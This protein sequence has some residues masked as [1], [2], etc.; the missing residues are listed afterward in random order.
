MKR[1]LLAG[2]LS[3]SLCTGTVGAALPMEADAAQGTPQKAEV[4]VSGSGITVGNG[5]I[6]RQ[7]EISGGKIKTS[8][9]QN[10]RI[11]KLLIPQDG[12]QDFVIHT[13]KPE[14][15]DG[16]DI[17]VTEVFPQ[18]ALD[19][20]GWSVSI[21]NAAGTA[22]SEEGSKKLIDGDIS[23]YP[24][25]YR[26]SGNPFTVDIDFG[27]K[28]EI[29]SMS[30]DK[31]PGF[32][33]SQYG[34]N[35]T[36]GKFELYTSED[37]EAYHLAYTGDFKEE[38]YQ[39]HEEGG[40]YNVGKTVYADFGGTVTARFVRLV[41]KTCSL[42]T[43]QEFSSAELTIYEDAYSGYDWADGG[44]AGSSPDAI[45]SG[46][47]VYEGSGQADIEGGKKLSIHY[48][49]YEKNGV[50]WDIDQ[51]V[52]IKDDEHYMRSF[53]EI[54]V[55]DPERAAI[56][57]IDTDRFVLS[58]GEE[59]L[60][61]HPKDAQIDSYWMNAHEQM[62]GQPIYAQGMFF[63]CE[64]P[65]NDNIIEDNQI[66]IR[67]YSGKNFTK[68][69]EDGQL[70]VDGKFVSWQNVIGAAEGTDTSVVQTA[71]FDYIEDIATPTQFRKQYNSWYDNMMSITDE[72][73]AASFYGVEDGLSSNGVEPLDCYVV[74]DGWNNYYYDEPD[75]GLPEVS[76]GSTQGTTPNKTG[77]WEFN[78]KFPNEL[79]TSASLSDKLK[80][81]FGMW[82]GPQGGYNYYTSFAKFLEYKGTGEVQPNSSL[83]QVI[84]TGSRTYL[85]NF[86]KMALDYQERFDIDYWKWDGF[87]SRPCSS[88]S[89]NHMAGG[90]DNMYFTSDMWEAWTD[91]FEHVRAQRQG[92][93]KGLFI[94][95]TCY[96]NL[97]PW[98]L[99]WV[100]TVWLQE[101]GDTGHLG[102]GER[103]QQKIYYRDQVYYK[104]CKK[105]EAQF[106]LKNI[107]NHDPI[108]G[109]SDNS[110]AGTDVFREFLFANAVRGTAFWELYFSPSIMDGDKWKV[111][112]DALFWAQ[113][114]HEILKNA[115]LFGNEP[116]KGVYGYSCWKGDQGIVSFTNP[117]DSEQTYELLV[118]D[119]VGAGKSLQNATGI[120]VYPYSEEV[121]QPVSYGDTIT[122]TLKPHQT[123]IRQYG[124]EDTK[125]PALIS[126]KITGEREVTLKFDERIKNGAYT[127]GAKTAGQ[128]LLADYRTVVL[129]T[130]DSLEKGASVTVEVSDMS[131]NTAQETVQLLYVKD[132]VIGNVDRLQGLKRSYDAVSGITW[133]KDVRQQYTAKTEGTLSGT[134]DFSV[135]TGV[136]TQAKGVDLVSIGDG[137]RLSIDNDGF[138]RF[139]VKD[140]MISSRENVTTVTE[141][142]HGVFGT[143]EYVPTAVK[144]ETAGKVNDGSPHMVTAVR[145]VNGMLKLY[146]DGKLCASAYEKEQLNQDISGGTVKI[147]D[148]GFSGDLADVKILNYALGYDEIPVTVEPEPFL[149]PSHEGWTATACTECTGTSG[150]AGAM[151][152]ID[153]NL[154]SWWH[155]D[156]RNGDP[157]T[158]NGENH[159]L[160]VRFE[161][162]ET[163]SKFLYTG[164]G[165]TING[166]IKNYRLEL[167]DEKGDFTT[168]IENGSFSAEETENVVDL[169]R[170]YT[171]Y[172][173]RLT[174]L[175]AQNGKDF[176]AAVE[177][178]VASD[179]PL[180]GAQE[181][182][183]VKAGLLAKAGG[184]DAAS[185]TKES[186]AAVTEALEI[187][188]GTYR[189][190]ALHM[191]QLGAKLDEAI[192]NLVKQNVVQ[193]PQ[194]CNHVE[195]RSVVPATES[196]DGKI[197]VSCQ[198]CGNVL[199]EESIY[200][201]QEIE[202]SKQSFIYDGKA[203]KPSLSV[204]DSM[205]QPIGSGYYSIS[206][207]KNAKKV[208]T[209]QVAVVFAGNYSGTAVREF[210]IVPKGTKLTQVKAKKKAIGVKW[211][212][213][214]KEITGYEIQCSLNRNFAKKKTVSFQFKKN[215]G[216]AV[217][218]KLKG[219]KKYFV[220]IRTYKNVSKVKYTSGW[221]AVKQV[222]AGK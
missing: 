173:F 41:Q 50:T 208:G 46:D 221:S 140:V 95:A 77:F 200:K 114:N 1:Q 43:A 51:V 19:K 205:G 84:C 171:A 212:K 94:N 216:S 218:K 52:V 198:A 118:T 123:V 172:G 31:R 196:S 106:P 74:D 92:Q 138:V 57:F 6:S 164:R 104:I 30:V 124:M 98:L 191:A 158:E 168:V 88:K 119:V 13:I 34:I 189:A 78:A 35:G 96:V 169:D 105:N 122:V 7:Y 18:K 23:T 147:A 83:G 32:E 29:R 115:K 144:T 103:H 121:M 146:V 71:F 126:A 207:S 21:K 154:N 148:N 42:G 130:Q 192:K 165:A 68:L 108:Y 193:P 206:Y 59:G 100:N 82:V 143:D 194:P 102:T 199:R 81:K 9:V 135:C 109:V 14:G 177:V 2:L 70:T 37:G 214:K 125:E 170:V 10:S 86:E 4:T 44:G 186:A 153:R 127:V 142:A 107:Y 129:T 55:S 133:I 185:Y 91:L 26:V 69:K 131:G 40:L 22:F 183:E 217:L 137:V 149:L 33:T 73:I 181:L 53:L 155:T 87:A 5:H 72:S 3:F 167:M 56:D 15:G 63:G 215:V 64:F 99:Q 62:L 17:P 24:D 89:H 36:M 27:A 213:Q 117:L 61:S 48:A 79:Y 25:E 222:K 180:L 201:I 47:L 80:S 219:G 116:A 136:N 204:K 65:A 8:A 139:S 85:K 179:N 156:Y 188:Q 110:S 176:A 58:G 128:R 184:F 178:D 11:G 66:Q 202:L 113:E 75:S 16:E 134:G 38:A 132:G 45:Y 152:S 175:S 190:T 150:D 101:S 160:C 210:T 151:A 76:P 12:S 39:L 111:T 162:P 211:K 220:R 203:K 90:T 28:K 49:P 195:T 112:A 157:C 60:W 97:S 141:K 161:K 120:Q 163:F 187:I 166:S 159:W 209:Y 93:G 20:A 197:T 174:C 67:Y 145:E 54:A 182:E